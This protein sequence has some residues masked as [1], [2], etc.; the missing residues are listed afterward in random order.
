MSVAILMSIRPEWIEKIAS[1]EKTVEVR[2]TAPAHLYKPITVYMYQTLPDEG[3]VSESVGHIVGEFT[4]DGICEIDKD[5]IGYFFRWPGRIQY[6][7]E[8]GGKYRD[9]LT[10][11]QRW[12]Y[13]GIKRGYG[14]HIK[15]VRMYETPVPLGTLYRYA[16]GEKDIRPCQNGKPCEHLIYD[17]SED[18]EAC[19]IDFDGENCPFL[20]V[21]R[22]PLSWMYVE[23]VVIE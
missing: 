23:E 1:R 3:Y 21:Q 5:S 10:P 17:Y 7:G 16:S 20:R 4:C 15:D 8:P 9:C 22:P 6:A 2:K 14:W 11:Q 13:L 19:A 12:D 18:C